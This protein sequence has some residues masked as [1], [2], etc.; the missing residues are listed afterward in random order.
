MFG[1]FGT[2]RT[3]TE[4]H[5]RTLGVGDHALKDL[6][7]SVTKRTIYYTN[8]ILQAHKEPNRFATHTR[9]CKALRTPKGKSRKRPKQGHR[10][11]AAILPVDQAAD[12]MHGRA[13]RIHHRMETRSRKRAAQDAATH[14]ATTATSQLDHK[15]MKVADHHTIA[16]TSISTVAIDDADEYRVV[17]CRTQG[18]LRRPSPVKR[19]LQN[20]SDGAQ[21]LGE[22]PT[23]RIRCT[24]CACV[25]AASSL[26]EQQRPLEPD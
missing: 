16:E 13:P 15:R 20:C 22:R 6:L 26:G 24:I 8:N 4:Q 9:K 2:V 1:S 23:K 11:G 14:C 19:P 12:P 3:E 5:L 18:C 21:H 17:L 10:Q 25:Q 7:C